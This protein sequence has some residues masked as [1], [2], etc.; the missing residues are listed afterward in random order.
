V[1][2]P[3]PTADHRTC[4]LASDRHV[5]ILSENTDKRTPKGHSRCQTQ[6]SPHAHSVEGAELTSTRTTDAPMDR[7]ITR[8]ATGYASPANSNSSPVP[9]LRSHPCRKQNPAPR[10]SLESAHRLPH[11]VVLLVPTQCPSLWRS[12]LRWSAAAGARSSPHLSDTLPYLVRMTLTAPVSVARAKTSYASIMS[13][14]QK[15]W[16]P[17]W[18]ASIW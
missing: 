12:A 7:P 13:S 2:S 3:N 9:T 16:V 17:N 11:D 1:Q 15:W 18:P 5:R 14:R 8:I 10:Q 6:Q 4:R